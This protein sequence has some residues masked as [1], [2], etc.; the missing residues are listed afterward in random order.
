MADTQRFL[1]RNDLRGSNYGWHAN[2]DQSCCF[3][4]CL[5][6]VYHFGQCVLQTQESG[7]G[8]RCARKPNAEMARARVT[9]SERQEAVAG[10]ESA[11]RAISHFSLDAIRE[12]MSRYYNVSREKGAS[13]EAEDKLYILNH[14]VFDLPPTFRRDSPFSPMCNGYGTHLHRRPHEA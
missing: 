7:C 3:L 1:L 12:G 11:T 14:Y 2:K 10:I 13:S 4:C 9:Q 5:A 8:G 6:F